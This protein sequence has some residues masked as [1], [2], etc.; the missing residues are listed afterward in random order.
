[1]RISI[2][3]SSALILLVPIRAQ[4][5]A[6]QNQASNANAQASRPDVPQNQAIDFAGFVNLTHSL[7]RTRESR[8]VSIETFNEMAKDPKT[9]ILDTRSK[10]AFDLVH[11]EAAMHLNFSDFSAKK[12]GEFIPDKKTRILIYCNNN[13][14]PAEQN[15]GGEA[16]ESKLNQKART[17]TNGDGV[18][19]DK[20]DAVDE[21][22]KITEGVTNKLPRLAL[23]IPTFV[24]LHGYGYT[25]VYELADQLEL[26]D[27]R[28]RLA[29]TETTVSR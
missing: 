11:V 25:N 16:G 4:E 14:K 1:M 24:N 12:L 20:D 29:K 7:Q 3:I 5:S 22:K 6:E 8:R 27:G 26:N 21:Q 18:V 23:N 17:D 28:L 13:F 9:I 19:D 2:V 15:S 10:R